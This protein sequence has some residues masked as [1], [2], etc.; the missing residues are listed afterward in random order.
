MMYNFPREVECESSDGM[1]KVSLGDVSTRF[2]K[3]D[4]GFFK[5]IE[6]PH[7]NSDFEVEHLTLEIK[8]KNLLDEAADLIQAERFSRAIEILDDVL[9]YDSE[10]AEALRLKSRALYG[11]KH[12]VKA[13]RYYKRAVCSSQDMADD[14]Y[15]ECLLKKSDEEIASFPMIKRNIY[16]GDECFADGE[17]Q[18]ALINYKK[19]LLIPSQAREKIL[20]KLYNKIAT[21]H[22]KLNEF[23]DALM[24]FNGSLNSL[25]NDY[26]WY[27][28][29]ICEYEMNVG[30]ACESLSHSVKLT[31]SQLLKKGNVLNELG[32]Y[33]RA[34]ETFDY[35][36]EN[37][38]K[39]DKIYSEAV[40][41]R[42]LACSDVEK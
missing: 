30:G 20:F 34:L 4:D 31:K 16:A 33:A 39:E 3:P 7:I 19:S 22:Y 10:Y 23:E 32:C 29:G 14:D 2:L 27:G 13:L 1:M 40:K 24:Y 5:R 37:H 36:L 8:I 41:G 11:E 35:I 6:S 25:N 28:K 38:F 15:Q 12:Y 17:Y 42:K 26:A 9:F 18:K 21:T